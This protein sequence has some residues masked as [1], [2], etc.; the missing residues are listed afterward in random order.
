MAIDV[1]SGSAEVLFDHPSRAGFV[2][3]E[4]GVLR[5]PVWSSDGDEIFV[6]YYDKIYSRQLLIEDEEAYPWIFA[7]IAV[8]LIAVVALIML[9]RRGRKP[10]SGSSKLEEG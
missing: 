9:L 10:N 6:S 2:G 3:S 7:L 4:L 5:F 8:G 1:E